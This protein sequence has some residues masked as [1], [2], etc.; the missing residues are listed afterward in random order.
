MK[1]RYALLIIFLA[2]VLL[3]A[4]CKYFEKGGDNHLILTYKT[5]KNAAPITKELSAK[6][7][8]MT[9]TELTT[10]ANGQAARIVRYSVY[11][12]NYDADVKTL[13]REMPNAD[14][15]IRV[16]IQV[17]GP[18]GSTASTA[19][20]PGTYNAAQFSDG[21]NKFNKALDIRVNVF[22]NGKALDQSI[23]TV[24]PR[25]GFVKINSIDDKSVSGEVDMSDDFRSVK[26]Q[27]NAKIV[28]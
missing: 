22:E 2:T 6:Q 23:S 4:G 5:D 14:G 8:V 19:L 28:K 10:T 3:A 15:Q 20:K 7:S 13:E 26:G 11:M 17:I 27:F 16:E 25:K 21:I 1:S 18:E 24:N 9:V 12:S